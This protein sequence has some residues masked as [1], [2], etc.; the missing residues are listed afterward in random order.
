MQ[1]QGHH[2]HKI[3]VKT[4]IKKRVQT[5]QVKTLLARASYKLL[6]TK[7][8]VHNPYLTRKRKQDELTTEIITERKKMKKAKKRLNKKMTLKKIEG[9]SKEKNK[10]DKHKQK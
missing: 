3:E 1:I 9:E 6:P 10:Q 8:R 5:Y 2:Q 4:F 7:D